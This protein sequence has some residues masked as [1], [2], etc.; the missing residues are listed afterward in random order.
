MN[1]TDNP[2]NKDT[3]SNKAKASQPGKATQREEAEST[4]AQQLQDVLK[5]LEPLN[6]FHRASQNASKDDLRM[7]WDVRVVRGDDTPFCHVQG[8][9]SL[10]LMLAYNM[11]ATAPGKIQEE[12]TDKIMLPLVARMQQEAEKQTFENV[13]KRKR[14][15]GS[16]DEAECFR[17]AVNEPPA[18]EGATATANQEPEAGNEPAG[19]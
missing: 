6:E 10:P 17:A 13:E 12:V 11:V 14:A 8:T 16:I 7:Y 4:T 15:S 3:K 1:Q 2:K 9:T 19:P 5:Q 18:P